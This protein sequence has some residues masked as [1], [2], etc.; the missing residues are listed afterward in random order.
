MVIMCRKSND[1][2]DIV[3]EGDDDNELNEWKINMNRYD[4]DLYTYKVIS[5]CFLLKISKLVGALGHFYNKS[6]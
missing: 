5:F 1:Q 2:V 6:K 3:Y 4:E